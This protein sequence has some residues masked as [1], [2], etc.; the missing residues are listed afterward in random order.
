MDI[1]EFRSS[2]C[3][4]LKDAFNNVDDSQNNDLGGLFMKLKNLM[5]AEIH[6]NWDVA[7]LEK[8]L[9][10][11]MVPRSLR[12]EITPQDDES[13]ISGWYKYFNDVGLDLLHFLIGRKRRKLNKLDEDITEVKLKLTPYKELEEYKNKSDNLK[14]VL[15]K[16]DIDQKI[17]KKKKYIRDNDDYKTNQVFKWR[18]RRA[19]LANGGAEDAPRPAI[20]TRSDVV[21]TPHQMGGGLGK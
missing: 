12:F 21:N 9:E 16:E 7:F 14:R 4:D 11:Q 6:G 15:E 5:I 8:Y 17:K 19:T 13:D 10:D 3:I 1:F 20:S 18:V 2:R